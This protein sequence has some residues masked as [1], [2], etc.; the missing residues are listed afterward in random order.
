MAAI[1][2]LSSIALHLHTT[3]IQSMSRKEATWNI[4]LNRQPT[5]EQNISDSIKLN[6]NLCFETNIRKSTKDRN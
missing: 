1:S 6:Q 3:H 4:D 5:S 2:V